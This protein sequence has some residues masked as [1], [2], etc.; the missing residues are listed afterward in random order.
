MKLVFLL[1]TILVGLPCLAV[2][3]ASQAQESGPPKVGD[4]A[5]NFEL[6]GSD[7]KNYKLSDFKGKQGVV[8]AWYPKAFTRG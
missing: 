8:V 3:G 7:G 1:V 4:A 2:T 5:P 6:K